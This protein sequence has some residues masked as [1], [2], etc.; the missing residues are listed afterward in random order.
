MPPR[1][2]YWTILVGT[3][4]TA[5][6]A[7]EREDL[8][9]TFERLRERHPEVVLK[10]FARGRLWSSPEEARAAHPVASSSSARGHDWRPGGSHRDPRD[11]FRKKPSLKS[12][13][14]RESR[15]L[16]ANPS[17]QSGRGAPRELG[18]RQN[19]PNRSSRESDRFP[20]EKDRPPRQNES[21]E[22]RPERVESARKGGTRLN[23]KVRR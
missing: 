21:R 16:V 12:T 2:A 11:R 10:W 7:R 15:L 17:R 13:R 18:V 23:K 8:L 9:P 1:Y 20:R 19:R 22:D 5:F 3:S 4:P 14:T 6:R